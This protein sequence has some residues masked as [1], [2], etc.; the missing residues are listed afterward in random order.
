MY[1]G[2]RLK[3]S[4]FVPFNRAFLPEQ[5]MRKAGFVKSN[6]MPYERNSATRD[7]HQ[8]YFKVTQESMFGAPTPKV[9]RLD[10]LREKF[11]I[12][13]TEKGRGHFFEF[14]EIKGIHVDEFDPIHV[15]IHPADEKLREMTFKMESP[16]V[17]S[18][19]VQR[20]ETLV[21]A[22]NMGNK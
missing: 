18:Q 1:K 12:S 13:T 2:P 5:I 6:D 14:S 16:E 9:L 4:P 20:L 21:Q 19:F 22:R 15:T 3:S 10:S 11:V 7:T 17:A 8:E